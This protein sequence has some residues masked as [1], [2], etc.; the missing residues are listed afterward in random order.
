MTYAELI[1]M[2][3]DSTINNYSEGTVIKW[4]SNE[5]VDHLYDVEDLA[6]DGQMSAAAL[7]AMDVAAIAYNLGKRDGFTDNE[8]LLTVIQDAS[9]QL[10]GKYNSD[11]VICI[12]L[13]DS[14]I[15][16]GGDVRGKVIRVNEI[17]SHIMFEV[18][19]NDGVH[20]HYVF[21]SN[22]NDIKENPLVS[23]DIANWIQE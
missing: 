22:P 16:S 18:L 21:S 11:K 17:G 13:G 8:S 12:Q 15:S 1:S 23:E 3:R 7:M 10:F 2:I 9:R 4:L 19:G 5:E 20:R 14:L 6:S